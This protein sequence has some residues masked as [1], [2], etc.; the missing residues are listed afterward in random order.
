MPPKPG[1][2]YD[3]TVLGDLHGCYSC[4]KAALMQSDFFAKVEAFRIDP[5]HNPEPKLILA[6][7][8]SGNLDSLTGKSVMD[9]FFRQ[10]NGN[11]ATTILV[12][13]NQELANRC[14]RRYVLEQGRLRELA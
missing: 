13:H 2:D 8:P 4:L 10:V 14:A 1:R 12:T 7:E 6:D 3:L 11:G 5:K 9:S